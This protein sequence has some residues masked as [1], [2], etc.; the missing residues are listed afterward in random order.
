MTEEARKSTENADEKRAS[1]GGVKTKVKYSDNIL[2]MVSKNI[3][4]KKCYKKHYVLG[5]DQKNNENGSTN[6]RW[7]RH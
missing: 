4:F 5:K 2:P 3:N 7:N 1:V 6:N